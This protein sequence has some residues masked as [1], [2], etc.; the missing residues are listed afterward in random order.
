MLFCITYLLELTP[1]LSLHLT[2]VLLDRLSVKQQVKQLEDRFMKLTDCTYDILVEKGV[3]VDR[4]H[5]WLISLDVS[6]KHE[7]QEFISNHLMNIDQGTT[8]NNLWARLGSCW[9][10]LNFGLLEHIINKFGNED[11]KQKM[12]SYKHDL[13]SFRKSTRLYD[14]I[15]CWPVLGETPPETEL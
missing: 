8:L 7:H 2:V 15:N 14:F 11:L 4:L 5:A 12:K 1:S 9:N 6:R 3:D 13:Q 10:F